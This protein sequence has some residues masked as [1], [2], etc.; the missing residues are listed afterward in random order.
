MPKKIRNSKFEIRNSCGLFISFE[1]IEGCGKSTQAKLLESWLKAQDFKVVLTREPGGPS[2]S[3]KIRR[4]L[5][6][7]RNK[8]MSDLTE[9]LLL[10]ASRVQHLAQVI[11]PALK[12]G[13]VVI[14]DRFADS[15]TAYQGYGRGMDLKMVNALN[16]IAVDGFWPMLTLVLD[17]PVEKGFSRA[18]GRRRSLDRMET[19]ALKF[20]KKVRQGF[21]TIAQADPQ[22]VKILDGSQPPDV[23]HAAVRQLALSVMKKR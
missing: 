7:N 20:H 5:L 23:I 8:G 21:K 14:C 4:I 6:D 1:G 10:Q 9:L 3:E 16:Q 22:R 11:V 12:A 18:K 2:I 17:L 19:Q 15:S 13:K